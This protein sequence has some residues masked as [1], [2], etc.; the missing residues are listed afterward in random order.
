MGESLGHQCVASRGLFPEIEGRVVLQDLAQPVELVELVK[1]M[2]G[3]GGYG[4]GFF[5][6][7]SGL[8]ACFLLCLTY[9]EYCRPR[10]KKGCPLTHALSTGR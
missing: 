6:A 7:A 4:A 9:Q 10:W 8:K 1:P 3:G 5:Y 2:E